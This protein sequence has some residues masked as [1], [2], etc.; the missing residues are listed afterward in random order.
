MCHILVYQKYLRKP[1]TEDYK[2]SQTK[3]KVLPLYLSTR[4]ENQIDKK[5]EEAHIL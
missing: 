2:C 1:K 3:S 5:E 4:Y